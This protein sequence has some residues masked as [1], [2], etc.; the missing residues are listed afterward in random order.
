MALII[1]SKTKC[2]LCEEPITSAVDVVATTPFLESSH[3]LS[4]YADA[5]MHYDCFQRWHFR[6]EFVT[7]YNQ[8]VGSNEMRP[9]GRLSDGDWAR[10]D[11]KL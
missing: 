7:A 1:L 9:D 11:K 6:E 2:P 4:R 3:L 5:T 8:R 10:F